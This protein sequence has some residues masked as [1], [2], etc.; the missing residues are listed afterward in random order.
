MCIFYI[1]TIYAVSCKMLYNINSA[2]I[3]SRRVILRRVEKRIT[4][5]LQFYVYRYTFIVR[6]NIFIIISCGTDFSKNNTRAV[7]DI[8]KEKKNPP[9]HPICDTTYSLYAGYVSCIIIFYLL[10]CYST[11]VGTYVHRTK[12]SR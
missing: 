11:W 6:C 12:R 1:I 9:S 3:L 2:E 10:Y 4:R 7:I 8:K 5:L